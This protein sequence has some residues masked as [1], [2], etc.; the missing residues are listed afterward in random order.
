MDAQND[1]S[2]IDIPQKGGKVSGF[3]IAS[4]VLAVAPIAYLVIG[5]SVLSIV[6]RGAPANGGEVI[7]WLYII[8][9]LLF[10]MAANVLSIIFGIIGIIRKR[11]GF[12]WAGIVVISLEVLALVFLALL[13]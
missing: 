2:A 8:L 5:W 6:D 11:I 12:A 10:T 1:Q 13:H 9:I 7:F 3:S 4:F